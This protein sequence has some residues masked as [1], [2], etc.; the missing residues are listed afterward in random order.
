MHS[1]SAGPVPPQDKSWSVLTSNSTCISVNLDGWNDGGCPITFFVVQY[2]PH[3]QQDW[4]LLS[5]NIQMAQSPVTIPDLVPG[6]WY[7]IMVSSY[8]DAGATEVEYRLATLTLSGGGC[9]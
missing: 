4:I 1:F 9:L 7:D 8:N 5:N 3:M 2:K 6:T